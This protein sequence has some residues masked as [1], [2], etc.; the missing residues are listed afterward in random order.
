MIVSGI[1]KNELTQE[2]ITADVGIIE[3][4]GKL[5]PKSFTTDNDKHVYRRSILEF[6]RTFRLLV[7]QV[8]Y[9]T[10]SQY[11]TVEYSDKREI[12]ADLYLV[13]IE[14]GNTLISHDVRFD[15]DVLTD[16]GLEELERMVAY[17][18]EYPEIKFS[19]VTHVASS[20]DTDKDKSLFV[21]RLQTI[22]L[23]F[24]NAGID[25]TRLTFASAGSTEPFDNVNAYKIFD[26]EQPNG[27]VTFTIYA[28]QDGD[29]VE[30]PDDKCID[31]PGIPE[32]SGCP[33]I[34]EDIL[35]VFEQALQGIQFETAKAV[36]KPGSFPILDNV[37]EI[38][39]NNEAFFLKIE[40]HTDSQGGD[41]ANQTLSDNR[42][43]STMKYLTDKGVETHRLKAY[44]F[45]ESQPVADNATTAGRAKNR[46]VVFEVVFDE[47]DL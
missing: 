44:G 7:E 17:M 1:T 26:P 38:M 3:I 45:G 8:N 2:A 27:R 24:Q 5:E 30:D 46:R 13:P 40:G 34:A 37:V 12:E 36:I 43:N 14:V 23:F 31:E 39:K 15:G 18:N 11:L 16:M 6:P 10:T 22:E 21:D 25:P 32:N 9:M 28:D 19:I 29:G 33:E 42:S 47:E 41:D 4:D 35:Q 20:G